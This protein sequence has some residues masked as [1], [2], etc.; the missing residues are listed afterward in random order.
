MVKLPAALR[1]PTKAPAVVAGEHWAKG[2]RE[3]RE[4][5]SHPHPSTE[6]LL[7]MTLSEFRASGLV[8]IVRCA[9]LGE[10]VVWAADGTETSL[11]GFDEKGRVVYR[12]EELRLLTLLSP[13]DQV[14][15]HALRRGAGE[16]EVQ[17]ITW[18]P[19]GQ[20]ESPV[21]PL[22]SPR[23]RRGVA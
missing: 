15:Y 22:A 7:D 11:R 19:P 10:E 12:G 4:E 16:V 5:G 9:V 20:E 23:R 3:K 14:A 1:L 21:E 17:S 6:L 13:A 18:S 2:E 8:V